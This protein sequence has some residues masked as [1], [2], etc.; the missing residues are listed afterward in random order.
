MV[1]SSSSSSYCH[2][3]LT[4]S[5]LLLLCATATVTIAGGPMDV[6]YSWVYVDYTFASPQHRESAI[7]SRRFIPENCVI[8]DVDGFQGK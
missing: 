3:G 4:A 8:L 1:S 5:V 2:R 6:E 7:K